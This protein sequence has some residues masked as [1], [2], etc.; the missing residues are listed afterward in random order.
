MGGQEPVVGVRKMLP[1]RVD[2]QPLQLAFSNV[3]RSYLQKT[4]ISWNKGVISDDFQPAF[5]REQVRPP[6]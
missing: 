3:I 4:R 1:C 6:K 5:T 2:A